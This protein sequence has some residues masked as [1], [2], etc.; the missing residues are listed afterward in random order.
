[1][2]LR[3]HNASVNQLGRLFHKSKTAGFTLIEL[4]MVSILGSIVVS[5]L[6]W[7]M[8]DMLRENQRELALS[9]TQQDMK[10]ALAFIEE[11]LRE[12]VYTY[13]GNGLNS[14]LS[15]LPFSST[16]TDT[17][18]IIAFW[19]VEPVPYSASGSLPNCSTISTSKKNEC[20]ALKIERRAYTLVMYLLSTTDSN[21][22]TWEGKSRILRYQLRKYGDLSTLTRNPGYA[23]PRLDSTF[24]SWP[25][26]I[27]NNNAQAPGTISSTTIPLVDFV[28]LPTD[29]NIT[30]PACP[31]GDSQYTYQ[32]TPT[33]SSKSKSFFA[34]VGTNQNDTANQDI[35][36]FLTGNA[37]GNA[38]L[39]KEE[40][41]APLKAQV[42][43]R[44]VI[45]KIVKE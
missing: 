36:L 17:I 31:A 6:L 22:K 3:F 39:D 27:D 25:R 38:G 8:N 12:A 2:S 11:D 35:I 41:L 37:N 1:M 30:P 5:G 9:S 19:K 29:S 34:C 42:I 23:D 44:G 45:E 4:L 32:R 15:Y 21:P 24:T 43:S 10:R 33:D 20:E 13:D 18:P 16:S 28:A 14:I 7:V 40:L 26:D